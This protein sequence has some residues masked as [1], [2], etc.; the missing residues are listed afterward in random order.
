[1]FN[2]EVNRSTKCG[3]NFYRGMV[4]FS[5]GLQLYKNH[6]CS[7]NESNTMD[8]PDWRMLP[9]FWKSHGVIKKGSAY[10]LGNTKRDCCLQSVKL[11]I[12]NMLNRI[13]KVVLQ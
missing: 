6:H 8:Y 7:F 3:Q 11:T 5:L 13:L 10:S 1:M 2:N 12:L 9:A 4:T